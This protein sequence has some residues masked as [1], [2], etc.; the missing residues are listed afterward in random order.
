MA[1]DYES[2]ALEAALLIS[3]AGRELIFQ[4]PSETPVDEQKPWLGNVNELLPKPVEGVVTN[5]E[6]ENIDGEV[7]QH[8][9]KLVIVG[10]EFF[11]DGMESYTKVI[12]GDKTWGIVGFKEIKPGSVVIVYKVQIRA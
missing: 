11:P 10:G 4:R 7:I 9:D 12:D 3:E 2:I 1:I 8:G 5:Y 6:S